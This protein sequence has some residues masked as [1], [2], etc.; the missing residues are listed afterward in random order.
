MSLKNLG[1]MLANLDGE[2]RAELGTLVRSYPLLFSDVRMLQ[3]G[4]DTS[5]CSMT[6]SSQCSIILVITMFHDPVIT[7]LH[8][9]CHHNATLHWS[10]QFSMTFAVQIGRASCR[11]RVSSPV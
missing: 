8:N 9:S 1:Y 11:E 4:V 3:D 6:V 5:Q 10:L 7:M 2:K